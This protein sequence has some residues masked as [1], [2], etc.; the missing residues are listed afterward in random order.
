MDRHPVVLRVRRR[1]YCG[2][3]HVANDEYCRLLSGSPFSALHDHLTRIV[4]P[5]PALTALHYLS[6]AKLS[7]FVWWG[8]RE[9]N[10]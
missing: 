6:L 2:H 10:D 8:G 5:K 4:Q 1:V 3:E 9:H 7:G